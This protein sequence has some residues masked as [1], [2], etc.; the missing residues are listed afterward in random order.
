MRWYRLIALIPSCAAS[1]LASPTI[2]ASY[3][4]ASWAPPGLLNSGIAPGSI[5]TLTGTGLGPVTL[6]QAQS[7]PLPTTGGLGGT[8]LQVTAGGVSQT[9][10]MV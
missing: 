5:F 6:L 7:Y 2:S 8:T 3:N 10:I 9:C 1:L 4:A